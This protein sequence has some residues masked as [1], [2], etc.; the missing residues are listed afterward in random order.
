MMS[1]YLKYCI[2][3]MYSTSNIFEYYSYRYLKVFLII[4]VVSSIALILALITPNVVW[5]QVPVPPEQ[6]FSDCPSYEPYQWFDEYGTQ[7]CSVVPPPDQSNNDSGAAPSNSCKLPE[8][9][10]PL[11]G[12]SSS[13]N[14]GGSDIPVAPS[15]DKYKVRVLFDNAEIAE[16]SKYQVR[17]VIDDRLHKPTV[18]KPGQTVYIPDDCRFGGTSCITEAGVWS[19][20]ESKVDIGDEIKAC[21]I[22]PAKQHEYCGY[23]TTRSRYGVDEVYIDIQRWTD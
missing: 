19:F 10:I 23:D 14:G 2:R 7:Y 12:E 16:N 9:Y 18:D 21:A 11:P 13:G 17:V 15:T 5:G 6:A 8:C 4:A 1:S 22:D 3:T 20:T